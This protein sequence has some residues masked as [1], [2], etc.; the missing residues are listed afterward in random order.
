MCDQCKGSKVMWVRYKGFTQ[1]Q[2]CLK[3]NGSKVALV[4]KNS[5]LL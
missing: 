2:P 1:C 3:C 4:V 5:R